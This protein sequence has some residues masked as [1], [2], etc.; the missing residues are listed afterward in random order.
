MN[1][2]A[3]PLRVAVVG[4]GF[5]GCAAAVALAQRGL[6]VHLLEAGPVLGG[7]A[8]RITVHDDQGQPCLL[9]NGQHILIGA[10]RELLGLMRTV[11][12]READVLLRL[13]LDLDIPGEFRLSCPR[14]PA[15]LHSLFG[16]LGA[17]GLSWAERLAAVRLMHRAQSQH[18]RLAAD[19]PV[20]DWLAQQRQPASLTRRLW[21]PLTLSALNTPIAQASAQVL[22]NVLRDSLAGPRAASDLLLP[23]TDLSACFPEAAA[24]F[25]TRHG[26]SVQCHTHIRHF[27]KTA[28]GW[29]LGQDFPPFAGLVLALPPHRIAGLA[30]ALPALAATL[31]PLDAWAYEPI[32]T[33]Y[34]RYPPACRLPKPMLGLLGGL[35]QWVFDRGELLGDAG[36]LAVV[37]SASGP[38]TTLP[39]AALAGQ[40]AQELAAHFP[41]LPPPLWHKVIAEKRATFACTPGLVRPG[42]A[43]PEPTLWLAGDYTASEYPA[44][45]EGAVRS[46]LAAAAGLGQTIQYEG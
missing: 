18:F 32:Y 7:R 33:V 11:G 25:I 45:L 12:L 9:D 46:G 39:Q 24:A 31:A 43:T 40:I 3:Q 17:R 42:N 34:L 30:A 36:L 1:L 20:A 13:P 23:R 21:E 15:P 37:I 35:G 5:A 19:L 4:G 26:G 16:L 22:L 38:H 29:H 2:P 27:E 14:L 10:Y 41:Y 6:S 28:E 8:R 44:T